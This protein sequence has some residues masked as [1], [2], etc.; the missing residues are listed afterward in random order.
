MVSGEPA[1]SFQIAGVGGVGASR[2]HDH[3]GHL[4][5]V[6]L[7]QLSQRVQIVVFE[8]QG[9]VQQASGDSQR[10][11]SVHEVLFQ[12]ST[13]GQIGR[14]VPV[15]PAVIAAKGHLVPAGGCPGDADGYHVGL[16]AA[17]AEAHHFGAGNDLG[18]QFGGLDLQGVVDGQPGT[19]GGLLL[20]SPDHARKGMPQK[21]R[22][23]AEIEVQILVAVHVP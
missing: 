15:V 12:G 22:A 19:P 4:T 16:P 11:D 23:G 13:R 10:G 9:G 20:N 8:G 1:H 21:Y 2:F 18:Q 5:P 17:L 7:Q 6:L 14:Q 3:A